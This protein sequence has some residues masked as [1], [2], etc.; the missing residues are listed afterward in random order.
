MCERALLVATELL[1]E[2]GHLTKSELEQE[3]AH[4]LSLTVLM[5]L[6][7][8]LD[9]VS[10]RNFSLE[11]GFRAELF[12]LCSDALLKGEDSRELRARRKAFDV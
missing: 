2:D 9:D 12:S 6:Q 11:P 3:C 4:H 10:D 7:W 1:E 8:L 5:V